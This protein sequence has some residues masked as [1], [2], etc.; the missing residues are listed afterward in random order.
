MIGGLIGR[1]LSTSIGPGTP[2]PTASTSAGARPASVSSASKQSS[3]QPSTGPGPSAIRSGSSRSASGTPARSQT[4]RRP[5]RAPRSAARTTPTCSLKARATGG[6]PPLDCPLPSR[7]RPADSSSPRRCV[8]VERERPVRS[9]TSLR[10]LARPSRMSRSTSPGE[11][12][13]TAGGM[14]IWRT[15][16]GSCAEVTTFGK[17]IRKSLALC[18]ALPGACACAATKT[19][20]GW[21][22]P[23]VRRGSWLGR[24]SWKARA[25]CASR[26]TTRPR[27]DRATCAS[28]RRSAGSA[29]EPS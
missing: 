16:V 12:F 13:G 7:S 11:P 29:T 20:L 4:A 19:S 15:L 2:T 23:P 17:D 6:R 10:V 9:I 18:G 3:S 1:P 5:W 8:T 22:R 27:S 26:P 24:S 28:A 21:R 14:T 25:T